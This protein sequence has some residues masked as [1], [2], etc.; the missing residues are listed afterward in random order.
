VNGEL[1]GV[2]ERPE[3]IVTKFTVR[4]MRVGRLI[5]PLRQ[6]TFRLPY[7]GQVMETTISPDCKRVV[8]TLRTI[9][10]QKKEGLFTCF[11]N[12]RGMKL[13]GSVP[14]TATEGDN[15]LF[16]SPRWMPGNQGVSFLYQKQLW[17][18]NLE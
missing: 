17:S 4:T 14:T 10:R 5:Y 3:P 1:P 12:G 13:L 7:R 15:G 6:K 9:G 18:V 16:Q 8:F 11:L 2:I